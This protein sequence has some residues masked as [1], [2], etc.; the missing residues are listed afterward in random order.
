MYGP[1]IAK[2]ILKQNRAGVTSPSDFR[3]YYK[4]AIIKTVCTSTKQKYRP[5][6]ENRKA[7]DKPMK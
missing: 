2:A 3:L 1:Q 5:M 4:A 7:K 6:K